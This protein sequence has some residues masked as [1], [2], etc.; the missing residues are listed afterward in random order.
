MTASLRKAPPGFTLIELLLVVVLIAVAASVAAMSIRDDDRHKLQQEG[1]R[2]SA[3]FRMAQSEARISGRTLVWEA[4]LGGYSFRT[5]SGADDD[6]LRD[7]L[8]RRRAWP[9]AVRRLDTPRIL[10]TR[11]PL[12]EPAVIQL[13][14]A[15]REL[16]LMLDARGELRIADCERESCA[17]SR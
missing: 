9:F 3:L 4:D 12:R 10:F 17:A 16:R 13:E 7:E 14:T 2:L 1:D 8:A 11:E 5:A 15:S 6:K